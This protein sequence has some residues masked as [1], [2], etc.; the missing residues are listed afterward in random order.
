MSYFNEVNELPMIV[1]QKSATNEELVLAHLRMVQA[2]VNKQYS[3]NHPLYEDMIQVGNMALMTAAEMFDREN[4]APFSAYAMHR[5]KYEVQRFQVDNKFQFRSLTTKPVLKAFYNQKNYIGSDGNLN[6]DKMST[7]LDISVADIR[8]MERRTHISF[9]SLNMEET[10]DGNEFHIPDY[11]SDPE[12]I[13]SE[14]QY[15]DFLQE[16]K[17]KLEFLSVRERAII[18]SRYYQD[19]PMSFTDLGAIY[20]VSHQRVAQIEQASMKKLKAMLETSYNNS[21]L[22]VN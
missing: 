12:T 1:D 21:K 10:E 16:M 20:G 13:L 4:G 6:R 19:E 3:I 2:F 5:I 9:V 15:E 11:E 8:E 22:E 7:D 18:E 17:S 14:L